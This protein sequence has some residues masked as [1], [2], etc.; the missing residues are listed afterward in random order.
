MFPAL[1]FI[2]AVVTQS[3]KMTKI[4][5]CLKQRSKSKIDS[6]EYVTLYLFEIVLSVNPIIPTNPQ[7]NIII[8]WIFYIFIIKTM[9]SYCSWELW[10]C[11]PHRNAQGNIHTA[12]LA[13][14]DM[15]LWHY[16]II[17]T[18]YRTSGRHFHCHPYKVL[19]LEH[20]SWLCFCFP[21]K[22]QQ[23]LGKIRTYSLLKYTFFIYSMTMASSCDV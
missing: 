16:L 13:T 6:I 8:Y 12:F 11:S 10:G 4:K 22:K 20:S 17:S 21:S 3:L 19:G 18:V 7:G 15:V 9:F 5:I 1:F 14:C 23:H 2:V